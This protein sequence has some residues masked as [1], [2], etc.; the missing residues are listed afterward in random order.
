MPSVALAYG[1]K[2]DKG[3]IKPCPAGKPHRMEKEFASIGDSA[4]GQ[5]GE[6]PEYQRR[7]EVNGISGGSGADVREFKPP[8]RYNDGGNETG[9]RACRAYVQK[10]IPCGYG[11][12]C[13]YYGP[14]SPYHRRNWRPGDEK[15]QGGQRP[16][17]PGGEVMP[18]LV[19]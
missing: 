16:V 10:R 1:H 6:Q 8:C 3:Y 19:R 17:A 4:E 2:V 5:V 12:F 13:F 11:G 7:A 14:E 9:K 15:R 18:H